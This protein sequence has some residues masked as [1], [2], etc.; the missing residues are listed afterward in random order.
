[1]G[2]QKERWRRTR[3]REWKRLEVSGKQPT[4]MR[5]K[6]LRTCRGRTGWMPQKNRL[7]RSALPVCAKAGMHAAAGKSSG[8]AQCSGRPDRHSSSPFR[9]APAS[10][11]SAYIAVM[12]SWHRRHQQRSAIGGAVGGGGGASR[13]RARH[14]LLAVECCSHRDPQL[15]TTIKRPNLAL[16]QSNIT[17][18][19]L[20]IH[21]SKSIDPTPAAIELLLCLSSHHREPVHSLALFA[22]L[23]PPTMANMDGFDWDMFRLKITTKAKD[24]VRP[25]IAGGGRGPVGLND[26]RR[27]ELPTQTHAS[28]RHLLVQ[29]IQ[30]R[31]RRRG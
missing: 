6:Q 4:V 23:Q 21:F 20:S 13:E 18:R 8:C 7:P 26:R 25:W 17:F 16:N 3:R 19:I 30:N 12:M 11:A 29:N 31:P 14:S 28:P 2:R 1:M 22:S 10:P 9:G 24:K 15:A 5:V 27:R